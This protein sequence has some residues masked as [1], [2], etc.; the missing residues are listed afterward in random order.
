MNTAVSEIIEI[1]EQYY[2][3][4]ES[5]L[6]DNRTHVLMRGDLFAVLDY[7]GNIVFGE[8][9]L[10]FQEARHLSKFVMSIQGKRPLSLSAEVRQDNAILW[11]DLANPDTRWLDTELARGIVHL[12]RTKFLLDNTCYENFEVQNYKCQAVT[13]ELLFEFEADF[14]DIFEVRGH[15]RCRPGRALEAEITAKAVTL[16]YEGLDGIVRRTTLEPSI[17]PTRLGPSAFY[18]TLTLQPQGRN[19]FSIRVICDADRKKKPLPYERAYQELNLRVRR[20][21]ERDADISTSNKQFNHWLN[22]SQAD[23]KM[24]T[25]LTPDGLYPYAGVPWFS[26]IFGRDGIITALEYLWLEPAIAKGVL[27]NLAATQATDVIPDRDAEPG[28][29]VHE[30][31]K[32]ELA[33]TGEVPFGRYYGTVDATPLFILLAAAYFERTRDVELLSS[34]WPNIERALEWIDEYADCDEDGFIEYN[35]SSRN[36]L[37][38]Q[39]WKDSQDSVFHA[40]GRLAQGPIALCEVQAY[41]YAAKRG[42][43]EAAAA[44]GRRALAESLQH[45]AFALRERFQAAFWCEEIGLYALA[46]DGAKEPCRVRSSNAGQCLFTGIATFEHAQ[47]VAQGLIA[48]DFYSGWG[49]RTIATSAARYNPM[50]YHNGSV[51]PHD[52]ALMA[53]GVLRSKT[54]DLA[55]EILSGLL[56]ASAFLDLHRLPELFCGLPRDAGRGPTLY[57]VACAPQAWAAGAVFLILQSCLGLTIRAEESRIYFYYPALP[58][59]VQRVNLRNLWVGN[60]SVDLDFVRQEHTVSVGIPRRQGDVEVVIVK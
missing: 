16:G 49:V 55:C 29:I 22:R 19:A 15:Q 25:T 53:F 30:I 56:D 41:V 14:A 37:A 36:G 48:S 11:V 12:K 59:S 27:S 13:F 1:N 21:D 42:I 17:P 6:A 46:L 52:N 58:K 26:T 39:G 24:L 2:V 45:Q 40:D 10:F 32:G 18:V 47:T 43:S 35:R 54:K 51:W 20:N 9:G 60:G 38:Q 57:P 28:K 31:R 5:S 3:K 50:S 4:A 23:L 7:S 44:L 8:Q 33:R 34:I